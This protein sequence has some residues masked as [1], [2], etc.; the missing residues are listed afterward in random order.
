MRRSRQGL[1]LVELPAMSRCK[2][3]LF[4]PVELPAMRLRRRGAFTLVELLVVIGI[5]ALLI[6]ILI[7]VLS[8]ARRQANQVKCASNIRQLLSACQMHAHE[9]RGYMPLAGSMVF[10]TVVGSADRIPISVVDSERKRYTYATELRYGPSFHLVPLP[11]AL[12]Q[13]LGYKHLNFSDAVD[14]D[15]QLND[16]EKGVW[17]LFMCPSTDSFDKP[18]RFAAPSSDNTPVGQGMMNVFTDAYSG[19]MWAWSTNSDFALNEGVF[20][21]HADNRYA[22]RRLAGKLSRIAKPSETMLLSDASLGTTPAVY[23][24]IEPWIIFR[25]SYNTT[26]PVTLADALQ[27]NFSVY[28]GAGFDKIRHRGKMNV[29]YADGHVSLSNITMADLKKVYL[30]PR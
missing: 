21:F 24:S 12:A 8:S 9:H 19:A 28:S 22:S 4:A 14:L 1:T 3:D 30:L 17:K 26:G 15:Q 25:P 16:P 10:Q 5:I 11:G 6:A 20:G 29:G 23:F 7:P 2:R 13:Y 27:N 18:R